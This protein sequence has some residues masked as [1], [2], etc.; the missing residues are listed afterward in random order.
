M[1]EISKSVFTGSIYESYTELGPLK[2]NICKGLV[3]LITLSTT[4]KSRM[5]WL[6]KCILLVGK[7][8]FMKLIFLK[9]ISLR[10]PL[11]NP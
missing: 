9:K 10:L 7:F 6:I 11:V 8:L 3:S 5:S 4:S 1:V 2:L